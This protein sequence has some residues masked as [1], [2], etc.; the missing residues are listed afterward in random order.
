MPERYGTA[1]QATDNN[2]IRRMRVSCWITKATNTR[3]EDIIL[4][5]FPR[6]Q[7]L[8]ERTTILDYMYTVSLVNYG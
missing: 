8:R 6:Q 5:A 1:R 3:S 4:T 7:C 2:I